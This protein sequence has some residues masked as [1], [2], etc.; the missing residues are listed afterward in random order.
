VC[1]KCKQERA[2][3][4]FAIARG[5]LSGRRSDC[6]SGPGAPTLACL[7]MCLLHLA[8]VPSLHIPHSY[9]AC[10]APCHASGKH[11]TLFQHVS[12]SIALL[13]TC[14]QGMRS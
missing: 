5:N 10:H 14:L 11:C 7:G 4:W 9:A 12:T 2:A 8:S 1:T 6:R 13:A 3:S